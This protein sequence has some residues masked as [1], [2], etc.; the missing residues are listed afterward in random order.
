MISPQSIEAFAVTASAILQLFVVFEMKRASSEMRKSSSIALKGLEL[1]MAGLEFSTC[2]VLTLRKEA[3]ESY[4]LE[5]CGQGPA[6]MAQWGY[7]KSISETKV[8]E[9]LHDNI[10]PAGAT[11]SINLDMNIARVYGVMLFAYSVTNDKFTT[12]IKWVDGDMMIV[13]FAPYSGEMPNNP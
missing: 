11:R 10:I 1:S 6:I 8:F 3:D 4:R 12:S 2:P 5:N 7:G 9:R 13:Y